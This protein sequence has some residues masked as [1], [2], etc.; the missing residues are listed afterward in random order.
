MQEIVLLVFV[1]YFE[2]IHGVKK[3]FLNSGNHDNIVGPSKAIFFVFTSSLYWV[4]IKK[5]KSLDNIIVVTY[6]PS[7]GCC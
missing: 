7:P 3:R 2:R 5:K 6:I 4:L 1:I